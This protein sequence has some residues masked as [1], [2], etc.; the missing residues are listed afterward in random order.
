MINHLDEIN[1]SFKFSSTFFLEF[2][3]NLKISAADR[4]VIDI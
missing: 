4:K 1:L 2:G 3:I